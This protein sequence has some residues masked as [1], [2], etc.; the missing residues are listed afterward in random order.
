MSIE[1]L[2]AELQSPDKRTRLR[3]IYQV[4]M[5]GNPTALP[6]LQDIANNDEYRELKVIANSAIQ[7]IQKGQQADTVTDA[8]ND[9]VWSQTLMKALETSANFSPD[10]IR[11]LVQLRV[12]Q[13]KDIVSGD[14]QPPT[15]KPTASAPHPTGKSV[16]GTYEMLWDC[17][18]C[19]TKKLLGV[20]HRFCPNCGA[21]QNANARYF[22]AEGEE[23]ALENHVYHGVDRICPACGTPVSAAAHFCG[24]CGS[25]LEGAATAR[26]NEEQAEGG[27]VENKRDFVA[28]RFQADVATS[29]APAKAATTRRNRRLQI[30]GCVGILVTMVVSLFGFFVVKM[31]EEVTIQQHTWERVYQI[32]EYT[33]ETETRDCPAP[34][35]AYNISQRTEQRSRQV[36]DGQDCEQVCTNRRVDQGDGSFRTERDCRNECT[37]RYRTEYYNVQVCTYNINRWVG[38]D[39]AKDAPWAIASG[40]GTSPYW[41]TVDNRVA[42]CDSAP[43]TLGVQCWK[44]REAT[45]ILELLRKNGK[46]ATCELD[47]TEWS[48]YLDGQKARVQFTMFSKMQNRA[49]C[50]ELEVVN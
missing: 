18:A 2:L 34:S 36:A 47:E 44:N 6:A 22:P 43:D 28:E 14:T 27:F 15:T 32:E 45:Y 17:E 42:S 33:K 12:T 40:Q 30:G 26:I 4:A 39:E 38:L 1:L 13:A 16:V 23:V 25:D 5:D 7:Y 35:G 8:K 10:D 24:N 29:L 50:D 20:T 37:T 3:A 49:L 31:S 46:I 21:T 41:P 11:D 19:G 9:V 48:Q